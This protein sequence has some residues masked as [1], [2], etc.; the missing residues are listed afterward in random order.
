MSRLNGRY[1]IVSI[2]LLTTVVALAISLYQTNRWLNSAS[3]ALSS[4]WQTRWPDPNQINALLDTEAIEIVDYDN[5]EAN[6]SWRLLLPTNRAYCLRWKSEDHNCA[7]Y[8][9]LPSGFSSVN[10]K[11]HETIGESLNLQIELNGQ[12]S[13]DELAIEAPLIAHPVYFSVAGMGR[14][15]SFAPTRRF[16]L[17]GLSRNRGGQEDFEIWIETVPSNTKQQNQ[18]LNGRSVGSSSLLNDQPTEPR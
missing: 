5:C 2:V 4:A 10:V 16:P 6:A 14:T 1:S 3:S 15:R 12:T 9:E 13:S 11:L 7:D 8:V 18:A 17:L